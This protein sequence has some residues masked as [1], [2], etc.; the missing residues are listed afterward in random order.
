M[1]NSV[2]VLIVCVKN[3]ADS[4]Y[5]VSRKKQCWNKMP[6]LDVKMVNVLQGN[7][8]ITFEL[9]YHLEE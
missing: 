8:I 5:I 4:M 9:Y 6:K 1:I 2:K 7:N 3:K